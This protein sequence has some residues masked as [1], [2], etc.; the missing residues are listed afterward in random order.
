MGAYYETIPPS[1]LTWIL[2]QHLFY[3]AS[4]PLSSNGHIN[5]SPKGGAYFGLLGRT[6]FW[7][8]E[9]TGSGN[10]TISHIHEPSNARI[11]IMFNAF[12]GPPKIIR[13]WGHGRV[14]ENGSPEFDKFVADRNQ[15]VKDGKENSR[16]IEVIPG[17][18]SI[19]IVDIEQVGS[20]CGFSVP[21]YEFKGHRDILNNHFDK[22]MQKFGETGDVK[23]GM[24]TYWAYKN[25][26]SMD[27]L[28]GMKRGTWAAGEYK[29]APIKK[30]CPFCLAL[31]LENCVS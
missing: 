28:P 1:L 2:A 9:L 24:D 4:A 19:I 30:V 17:T 16:G 10:E 25:A 5:V 8:Q 18:R 12:D 31:R 27:G 14:L 26:W 6:Q 11:C 15:E 22:K 13:L 21:Y 7:Y 23:D 20:S 3:V 29:V